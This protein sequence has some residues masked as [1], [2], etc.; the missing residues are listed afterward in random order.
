MHVGLGAQLLCTVV[1][2][3]LV[4]VELGEG[5]PG[6]TLMLSPILNTEPRFWQSADTVTDQERDKSQPVAGGFWF[7]SWPLGHHTPM[8]V[9]TH[10]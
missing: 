5:L 2:M 3:F 7:G 6:R 1:T 9:V 10:S 8:D 4:P